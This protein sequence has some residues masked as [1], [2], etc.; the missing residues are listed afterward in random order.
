[1]LG[2]MPVV[3]GGMDVNVLPGGQLVPAVDLL[4]VGVGI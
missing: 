2:G 1:M 3:V 4:H